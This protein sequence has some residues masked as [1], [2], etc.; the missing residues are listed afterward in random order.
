MQHLYNTWKIG[1]HIQ[2]VA[3]VHTVWITG[4]SKAG[5]IW[6]LPQYSLNGF[7]H[8][9]VLQPKQFWKYEDGR[10]K[11]KTCEIQVGNSY[12]VSWLKVNPITFEIG[13]QISIN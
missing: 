11:G 2:T 1:R 9:S 5:V 7:A 10:L 3:E 4:V 13:I 6:Y 8:V 12:N